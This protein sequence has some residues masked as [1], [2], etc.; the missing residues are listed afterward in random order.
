MVSMLF[1]LLRER[2]KHAAQGRAS[3]AVLRCTQLLLAPCQITWQKPASENNRAPVHCGVTWRFSFGVCRH[4]IWL[5]VT[6]TKP[7]NVPRNVKNSQISGFRDTFYVDVRNRWLCHVIVRKK[8]AKQ[9]IF[10]VAKKIRP[11]PPRSASKK[12]P[13]RSQQA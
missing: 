9:A 6:W 5:G 3:P 7:G 8:T 13:G 1:L 10:Y 12:L 11:D 4:V 2:K